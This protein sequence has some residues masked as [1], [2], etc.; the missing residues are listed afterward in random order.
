[1]KKN[2]KLNWSRSNLF[3][4]LITIAGVCAILLT[5]NSVAYADIYELVPTPADLYDLDH[6]KYYTWG[7]D[8]PWDINGEV[9]VS[10]T[11]SFE[12][13]RN[14]RN[15]PNVLYIHLLDDARLGVKQ[16]RDNQQGGDNF[17]GEGVLLKVY[18]NL[19]A[20]PQDLSFS[21]TPEQIVALNAYALDGRFAM[22][23]DPDCHF[24]NDGA[25][26][27]VETAPVPE[28]STIVLMLGIVGYWMFGRSKKRFV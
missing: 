23:F 1:M 3:E 2:M 25:K 28:P 15:E 17:A 5:C 12:N 13:I 16:Y 9:A 4:M 10:A 26:L 27:I 24:Y 18:R 8:T 14:W 11:F 7:I 20:T 6:H 21:F 22:G 19:P